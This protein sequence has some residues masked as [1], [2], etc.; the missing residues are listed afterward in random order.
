MV[1]LEAVWVFPLW[2]QLIAY[3]F[4]TNHRRA[5]FQKFVTGNRYPI[6]SWEPLE[7]R[8]EKEKR[9]R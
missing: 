6:M 5:H 4:Y 1:T 3:S 7:R 9:Q 8:W 2:S